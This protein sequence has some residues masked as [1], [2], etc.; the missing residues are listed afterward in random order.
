MIFTPYWN[1]KMSPYRY[2]ATPNAGEERCDTICPFHGMFF[3]MCIYLYI[4]FTRFLLICNRWYLWH[5]GVYLTT[6]VIHLTVVNKTLKIPNSKD[7]IRFIGTRVHFCCPLGLIRRTPTQGV[8]W[9]WIVYSL[10][11]T[12]EFIWIIEQEWQVIL[13]QGS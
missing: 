8:S 12:S 9:C 1:I 2:Q 5:D 11:S 6:V 3:K 13:S 7:I 4:C 10:W